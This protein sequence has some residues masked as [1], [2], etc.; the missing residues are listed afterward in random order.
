[1]LGMTFDIPFS[2]YQSICM[3]IQSTIDQYQAFLFGGAEHLLGKGQELGGAFM[4]VSQRG[5]FSQP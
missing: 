2:G 4:W 3:I 1:M 5:P